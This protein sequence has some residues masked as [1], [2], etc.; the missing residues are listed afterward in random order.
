MDTI[1]TQRSDGSY[2]SYTGM[3]QDEVTAMLLAQGLTCSLMT[4][5]DFI[6]AL[7]V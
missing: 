2:I 5:A 4:K 1:Y 6:A 7:Q 3:T